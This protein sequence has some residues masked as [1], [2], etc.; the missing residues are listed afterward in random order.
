MTCLH[1]STDPIPDEAYWQI[2]MAN[3]PAYLAAMAEY[4][5]PRFRIAKLLAELDKVK[6]LLARLS[7]PVRTHRVSLKQL[8]K[9]TLAAGLRISRMTTGE[10]GRPV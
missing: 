9:N 5:A 2:Q 10:R 6:S 7:R 4:Y 8:I 1:Y 3:D